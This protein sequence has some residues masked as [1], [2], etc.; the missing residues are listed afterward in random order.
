MD[1]A[2]TKL[3]NMFQPDAALEET[4]ELYAS[5]CDLYSQYHIDEMIGS[6]GLHG[7]SVSEQNHSSSLCH[8]NDKKTPD[9]QYCEEPMTLIKDLFARQFKLNLKMKK[10]LFNAET[11]LTIE[12]Q[13]L[14]E[15]SNLWRNQQLM[16]AAANLCLVEY[17][18][19]KNN[20]RIAEEDLQI[21]ST[22]SGYK[23]T[24]LTSVG[25]SFEFADK[26]EKCR[27]CTV[28]ITE[29][30][31][32]AH[33]IKL[34]GGFCR[35][36]FE[37][38]HFR[39]DKVYGSLRGWVPKKNSDAFEL[40]CIEEECIDDNDSI[41]PTEEGED[42]LF[43]TEIGNPDDISHDREVTPRLEMDLGVAANNDSHVYDLSDEW[44]KPLDSRSLRDILNDVNSYYD[45]AKKQV[46]MIAGSMAIQMR[47]LVVEGAK[48]APQISVDAEKETATKMYE[49]MKK[50]V[51]TYQSAFSSK[52]TAFAKSS[53]GNM[54]VSV[55]SQSHISGSSKQRHKRKS[56]SSKISARKIAKLRTANATRVSLT[57]SGNT[58][59]VPLMDRK[60]PPEKL[61]GTTSA[62]F[63]NVIAGVNNNK[64]RS[65][66]KCGFCNETIG[67]TINRCPRR[68]ECKLKGMEYDLSN[69]K[70]IQTVIR[71][72]ETGMISNGNID[73]MST[74]HRCYSDIP[75]KYF[76]MHIVLKELY[77]PTSLSQQKRS[78]INLFFKVGFVNEGG[79]IDS[80][81][82][83]W[84]ISGD[85]MTKILMGAGKSKKKFA[86]DWTSYLN[87]R[88]VM[89]E[90]PS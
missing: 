7:S 45:K 50:S 28:K 22:D 85:I 42:N 9:N 8:L 19:F 65:G 82:N 46:K 48:T 14:R 83:G 10:T 77:L 79:M 67:H 47:N 25:I 52:T 4:L 13:R 56:E 88:E 69:K 86:Y 35:S 15:D 44:V 43:N 23:I 89:T 34:R 74:F 18:R 75:S 5:E 33:E 3:R 87:E 54:K 17:H 40:I 26:T 63:E 73:P 16:K 6:R 66:N 59:G 64:K 70:D 72:I 1:N 39:R 30:C 68:D 32:C 11:E 76:K 12:M 61:L 80:V 29:Q 51:M 49:V 81:S 41:L 71:N 31:Q 90:D 57:A 24:S 62:R 27:I 78:M 2:K 36:D 53:M 21:S 60:S 38:R 20:L 84:L 58:D 37:S 55:P